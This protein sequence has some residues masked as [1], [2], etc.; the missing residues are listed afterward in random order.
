[1]TIRVY[2]NSCCICS[3]EPEIIKI[4][5]SSHKMYSNNIV[6]FQESTTILN[7]CTKKSVNLLKAPRFSR[8]YAGVYPPSVKGKDVTKYYY[9]G[10]KKAKIFTNLRHKQSKV[11]A[12]RKTFM[13]IIHPHG[14]SSRKESGIHPTPPP[15]AR[16]DTKAFYN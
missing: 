4:S 10:R 5:Q 8:S 9:I 13:K 16:C 15:W 1:M 6:N 3:F 11:E 14:I 2:S 7:A 12:G